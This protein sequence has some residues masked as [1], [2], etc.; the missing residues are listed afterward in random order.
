[1]P[2]ILVSESEK[3]S[4]PLGDS[5]LQYRRVPA[6]KRAEIIQK[7]TTFGIVD[8]P[9]YQL[10][11]VQYA[12]LGWDNVQTLDGVTVPFKPELVPT[13][14][15]PVILQLMGK[16]QEVSPEMV[17]KN[18]PEPSSAVSPSAA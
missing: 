10:D 11:M 3:L 7:R 1:V 2:I 18:S 14:P 8:E 9:G 15:P 17:T 6:L 4:L 16:I 5:T 12:L 13:L